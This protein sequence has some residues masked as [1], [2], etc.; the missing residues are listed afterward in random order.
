MFEK[1]SGNQALVEYQVY[2]M[3]SHVTQSRRVEINGHKRLK[4]INFNGSTL[5]LNLTHEIILSLVAASQGHQ[6][7][8]HIG[9]GASYDTSRLRH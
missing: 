1:C 2:W 5:T 6:L 3:I 9:G 8:A 7:A 4:H